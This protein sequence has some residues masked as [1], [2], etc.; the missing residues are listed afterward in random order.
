MDEH[1]QPALR[2]DDGME[3]EGAGTR[4]SSGSI[5]THVP[6]CRERGGAPHAANI[7]RT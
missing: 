1:G 3:E 5:D 4:S 7:S 6:A 2:P